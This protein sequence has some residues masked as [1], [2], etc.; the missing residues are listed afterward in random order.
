MFT[1]LYFYIE[2]SYYKCLWL[3]RNFH[4]GP[5]FQIYI[6]N[7][8]SDASDSKCAKS[9]NIWG[10]REKFPGH[11]LTIFHFCRYFWSKKYLSIWTEF[12]QYVRIFYVHRSMLFLKSTKIALS[13]REI[14]S[15]CRVIIWVTPRDFLDPKH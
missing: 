9:R 13:Y 8:L 11:I 1:N 10:T 14:I 2:H 7:Y 3:C 6:K 12:Q 15:M 4:S 5:L